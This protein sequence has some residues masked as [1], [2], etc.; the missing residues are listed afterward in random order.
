MNHWLRGKRG[1]ALAFILV[2]GLVSSGLGWLTATAL[3]LERE[4]QASQAQAQE[5]E[6]LRLALWRLDSLLAPVLAR[7][8][9]RPFQAY[10]EMFAPVAILQA[11]GASLPPGR[12]FEPSPLVTDEVPDWMLLHFQVDVAGRWKSPQVFSDALAKRMAESVPALS[13]VN[14]TPRRRE[15]LGALSQQLPAKELLALVQAQSGSLTRQNLTLLATTNETNPLQANPPMPQ[16]QAA[17]AAEFDRDLRNR[18]LLQQSLNNSIYS[19]KDVGQAAKSANVFVENAPD[20]AEQSKAPAQSTAAKSAGRIVSVTLGPMTSFWMKIGSDSERLFIMRTAKLVN[21]EI[22]QGALLDWPQLEAIMRQEVQDLF[23]EVSFHR[24]GENQTPQAER[25]LASLPI[26]LEPGTNSTAYS[27]DSWSGLRFGL[28]LAW[29][30]AL[31]ALTAVGLGG[32]SLL[33]LS[34]RRFR[35][36]SAVTHE[37]R[38]PLTTLRLY[39][40]MLAGGLIHE[41]AQQKEYLH[42]LNGEADRLNRL[43]GNVL[44]FSCLENQKPRLLLEQINVRA[45]LEETWQS[46]SSRCQEAGM[47]LFLE[48]SGELTNSLTTD[49]R[50]VQQILG[51]LIDNA[52]KYCG[53]ASDRRIRLRGCLASGRRLA[54]EVEDRGPGI[55]LLERRSIFRAFQRG[56]RTEVVTGGVGLGLALA[57]RWAKLLGGRLILRSSPNIPGACFRLELPSNS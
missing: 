46:W 37:L 19:R 11:D 16:G 47:E 54:L 10:S 33:D 18:S 45:L 27:Q 40:D 30:A 36:V 28:V 41:E 34:E 6:K 50:L 53:E 23:P 15:L 20:P 44:D 12:V 22:C 25:T 21:L 5:F 31:I 14:R 24:V 57:K 7:E 35:F 39:L 56:K 32:W 48:E 4:G 1:A 2:A 55:P 9:S 13:L 29:A 52:C 43:V 17:N 51:N 42:T 26:L 3:Q 8:D 49:P 38:T